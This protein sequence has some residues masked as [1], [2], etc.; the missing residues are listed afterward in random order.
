MAEQRLDVAQIG[1]ARAA[2]A[3]RRCAAAHAA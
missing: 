1:T 3:P 2:D